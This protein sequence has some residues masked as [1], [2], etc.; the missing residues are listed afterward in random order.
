MNERIAAV[1]D[2]RNVRSNI[3]ESPLNRRL[4]RIFAV[5]LCLHGLLIFV[6]AFGDTSL[7]FSLINGIF[8]ITSAVVFY[9][10]NDKFD[11]FLITHASWMF[12]FN[13]YVYAV[14]HGQAASY[15]LFDPVITPLIGLTFHFAALTAA[16]MVRL[17]RVRRA[18][19][20]KLAPTAGNLTIAIPKIQ[21]WMI[22]L[23]LSSYWVAA[24]FPFPAILAAAGMIEVLLWIGLG[25]HIVQTGRPRAD[26]TLIFVCANLVIISLAT[27]A[28][29]YLLTLIVFAAISYLIYARRLFNIKILI[30]GY[31][32]LHIMNV[33][34]SITLDI[35]INGGREESRGILAVYSEK[36]LSFDTIAALVLPFYESESAKNVSE[37]QAE[38]YGQDFFRSPFFGNDIGLPTRFV[39]LPQADIVCGQLGA[40]S[41]TNWEEIIGLVVSA[42]PYIGI[43]K[44]LIYSDRLTWEL[45]LRGRDNI[46]Y[47]MITAACEFYSMGGFLTCYL[48]ATLVMYGVLF[49]C[50]VLKRAFE[51]DNLYYLIMPQVLLFV[52]I[53]STA[54]S[55]TAAVIRIMPFI[56]VLLWF[57]KRFSKNEK[58][59]KF[60]AG[61]A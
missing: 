9:S 23:G 6:F 28:R 16:L 61:S 11:Y 52:M 19:N 1:G 30:L 37:T 20:P 27:N 10:T 48:L 33:F 31:L 38:R 40:V 18:H 14:A 39:V 15:G 12:S 21:Y 7:S 54:L 50:S 5:G 24:L 60:Y 51:S 36:I 42:L 13:T 53:T 56:F 43:E 22:F 3:R 59:K 47:P 29:Q 26:L 55:V 17:T 25:M 4:G 35:R 41:R 44:S 46:G 57:I 34:S 32:L 2:D 49:W 8:F 45:G 58:P